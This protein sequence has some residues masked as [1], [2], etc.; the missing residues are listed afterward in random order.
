MSTMAIA[1]PARES[2]LTFLRRLQVAQLTA[3]M[4][5][6]RSDLSALA[7]SLALKAV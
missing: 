3:R 1:R 2:C 6:A 4:A 7:G 5:A